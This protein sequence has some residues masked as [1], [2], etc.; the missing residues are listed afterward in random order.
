MED[1]LTPLK[2]FYGKGIPN[3]DLSLLTGKLI[4]I[5]GADGAGRT[6]QITMLRDRLER[7]G[8]PTMEVGLKRSELVGDELDQ[9]MEGNTL[10]PLAMSLFYATDFT[11]QLEK[12]ILP[13]LRSGFVVMADRYIYTLMARAIVRGVSAEWIRDVYGIAL[14]PDAVFYLEV[15]PRFLAER[16][17]RKYAS[18]DFWESGMDIQ[19]SGDI[20]ECFINYQKAMQ[21]I[22]RSMER[23]YDFAIINGNRTPRTVFQDLSARIDAFLQPPPQPPVIESVTEQKSEE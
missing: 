15:D 14:V 18:L 22:L 3:V 13:A 5:E 1:S 4:V 16:T 2:R 20:Y 17:F 19:R 11:D 9:A 6:T 7:M 21:G 8:F 12:V 23:D 10:G